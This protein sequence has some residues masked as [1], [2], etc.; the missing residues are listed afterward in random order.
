MFVI[1][2]GFNNAANVSHIILFCTRLLGH[3]IMEKQ[4]EK[5]SAR[6]LSVTYV[7]PPIQSRIISVG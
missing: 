3:Q 1:D 7:C 6:L 5:L 2:S 4:D